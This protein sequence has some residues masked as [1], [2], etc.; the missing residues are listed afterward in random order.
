MSGHNKWSQIKHKKAATDA[1]KSGVFSRLAKQITLAA[2]EGG[3]DPDANATLRMLMDKAKAVNMPVDN[4]SRAIKRGTG[5]IEGLEIKSFLYES[6][7]PGGAALLIEG[8][9]DNTNRTTSEIKH[10][11]SKIGAKWAESGSV[12]YLF[13]RKGI[14]GVEPQKKKDELEMKVI[15]AGA[16]DLQWSEDVLEIIVAPDMLDIV[17]D[18][19]KQE[20]IKILDSFLGYVPKTEISLPS[21]KEIAKLQK[22]IDEVSDHNDVSAV[23]TNAKI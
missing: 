10:L 13:E 4:V 21:E 22:I 18:G 8:A 11:L 20:K 2:K 12:L 5:E 15:D 1:K 3:G 17:V 16:Q 23:F 14:I 7:G 9:T 6:Y 19:L